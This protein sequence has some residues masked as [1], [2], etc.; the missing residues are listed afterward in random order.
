MNRAEYLEKVLRKIVSAEYDHDPLP[1]IRAIAREALDS[2]YP[3]PGEAEYNARL[4]RE[5][6]GRLR[7]AFEADWI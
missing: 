3:W 6:A 7:E 2:D 5:F 1:Y 4:F